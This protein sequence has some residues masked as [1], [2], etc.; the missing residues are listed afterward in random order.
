MPEIMHRF[1]IKA[2]PARIYRAITT[3]EG[4]R[5]W[6][7]RDADFESVNGGFGEFRFYGGT[8][9]T[10]VRIDEL[11]PVSRMRWTVIESFAPG[12]GGTTIDFHLT[13]GDDDTILRFAQRGFVV[14][15]DRFAMS[16][17]GWAMYFIS[18]QQYVE[19]GR[20]TPSPDLDYVHSRY[21]L[22]STH[23]MEE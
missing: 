7:T 14:A 18:L 22:I 16:T 23:R 10:R 12:W 13:A 17:T 6:W 21:R 1:H 19:T 11:E 5:N 2:E 8:M 4:L 20:G 3:A 15:D 9:V